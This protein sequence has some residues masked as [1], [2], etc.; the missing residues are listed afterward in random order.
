MKLFHDEE[1]GPVEPVKGMPEHLPDGETILWQGKPSTVALALNAFRLR[2]IIGYF[3]AMTVFRLANLS[4][5]EAGASEFAGVMTS[6]L[7][8]GLVSVALIFVLSFAMSRAAIF[9]VTNQRVVLRYGA[10]IRKYVNVPF[11]QMR[12]AQLKRKSA[13]VGDISMQLD[14]PGQPPYLHLWPFVRPFEYSRPQPMMRGI[15]D[16]DAVSQILARAV[17]ETAPETVQLEL[18]AAESKGQA[19][20][21]PNSSIPAV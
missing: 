1:D 19:S 13:R 3:I 5:N 4:S 16:A 2:W 11:S 6:S 18:G 21:A 8:F 7:V 20:A 12:G 17:F 14:G 15:E 10:A 9:T